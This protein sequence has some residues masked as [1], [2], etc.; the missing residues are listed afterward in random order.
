MPFVKKFPEVSLT[1]NVKF[2]A[3][4]AKLQVTVPVSGTTH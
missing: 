3:G 2:V 1:L 4:N